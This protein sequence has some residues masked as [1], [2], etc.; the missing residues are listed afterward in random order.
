[1]TKA[2]FPGSFD[3]PTW[4][5]LNIIERAAAMFDEL[6]VVVAENP[7]K[8]YLFS[9]PERL[10]MLEKLVEARP[11][12]SVVLWNG[13]IVEFL[14]ERNIRIL[15]RGIRGSSDLSYEFELSMWNKA[16]AP[17]VETIFMTTDPRFLVLRSSG[18]REV[19]AFGGDIK[20]MVPP[21]V[22]KAVKEKYR[23]EKNHKAGS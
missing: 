21:L 15:V 10:L 7:G 6:V 20:A 23:K 22:A 1:M 12:I 8:K 4:G 2:V 3:P 17:G 11:N 16:L 13:L 9:A 18:I 19:A 14:K 5:H